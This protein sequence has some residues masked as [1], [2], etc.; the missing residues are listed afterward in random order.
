MN[1]LKNFDLE[2]ALAGE[3]VITRDGRPVTEVYQF[4]SISM[5][6]SLAAVIN[7]NILWFYKNAC[8]FTDAT[9]HQSDLF[10]APTTVERWVN[11]YKDRDYFRTQ[12][13]TYSTKEEA[14]K[15]SDPIHN[16]IGTFPITITI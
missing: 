5:G 16:Y 4:R 6:K 14:V 7:G 13:Y 2:K 1:N 10:M 9:P 11:V 12:S 15:A 8:F 3:T